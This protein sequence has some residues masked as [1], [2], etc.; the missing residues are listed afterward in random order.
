[1]F[2]YFTWNAASSSSPG[3]DV[4]PLNRIVPDAL[5][6]SPPADCDAPPQAVSST[7]DIAASAKPSRI[8][9]MLPPPLISRP[10]L[11]T[12]VP[13]Q[14][15]DMYSIHGRPSSV[16]IGNPLLEIIRLRIGGHV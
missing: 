8:E 2:G 11:R 12:G 6:M 10:L 13:S 4:H 3:V 9:R 5:L 16:N 14:D 15:R 1:M 7:A